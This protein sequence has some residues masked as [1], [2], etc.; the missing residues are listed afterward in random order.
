LTDGNAG[1]GIG[2]VLVY[3][4][5][6]GST[7]TKEIATTV[8][9]VF[10]NFAPQDVARVRNPLAEIAAAYVALS[11]LVE[12]TVVTVVHDY[13]GTGPLVTG[14]WTARDEAL[15]MAVERCQWGIYEGRLRVVF[16]HTSGHQ[17][18]MGGDE[19]AAY[20]A[21]ADALATAAVGRSAE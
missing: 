12:G 7:K 3:R 17:S 20:N 5:P 11:A 4:C 6:D 15:R 18:A 19:I 13:E 16:R 1:G 10:P 9:D 21:R 8:L 2:V 14:R